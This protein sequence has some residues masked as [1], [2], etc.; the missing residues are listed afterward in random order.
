MNVRLRTRMLAL[1]MS[2]LVAL[3]SP[4]QALAE[5]EAG[6]YLEEVYV[7]VAKTPDE[8]GKILEGKGYK[9]LTGADGKPADLNQ[10]AGSTFKEDRAVV[11]GYKTTGERAKAITDLAVMGMDGAYSFSDYTTL[12]AKY[13]D[14][15]IRPLAERLMAAVRE[16]RENA[17]SDNAGNKA[18]AEVTRELLN[19]VIEDDS[20]GRLGDMLLNQTMQEIGADISSMPED[21]AKQMRTDHPSNLDL[22]CALTQG[23]TEVILLVEQLLSIATDSQPTTWLERL[24]QLGP[25]G[26]AAS[27]GD[28]RPSD[29]AQDMAAKYQDTAKTVANGWEPLRKLLLDYEATQLQDEAT[30]PSNADGNTA[31]S[32]GSDVVDP[33]YEFPHTESA[34][35]AGT[36]EVSEGNAEQVVK[37]V[38]ETMK[39][40]NE[41]AKETDSARA[42]AL[43]AYLK[44]MPYGE[45][46]LYDLFTRPIEDVSANGYEALYPMA[47]VLSPGQVAGLEF[48][49]LM[50]LATT[51]I[52]SSEAYAAMGSDF[53]SVID[54]LGGNDVSL[55]A[56]VNREIFSD[57]VAL[58]S[59]ALRRGQ[60]GFAWS[61]LLSLRNFM[62]LS[63]VGTAISGVAALATARRAIAVRNA[64]AEPAILAQLKTEILS[65]ATKY[66]NTCNKLSQLISGIPE[67]ASSVKMLVEPNGF[68]NMQLLNAESTDS[69]MVTLQTFDDRNKLLYEKTLATFEPESGLSADMTNIYKARDDI[70]ESANNLRQRAQDIDARGTDAVQSLKGTYVTAGIFAILAIASITLTAIDL[71]NYYN[72]KMAPIPKYIVDAEDITATA[73]DGTVTVVRNDSAYYQVART[74]AV[75]DGDNLKAMA[76]YADLNGDV[77]KGWLALYSN[78]STAKMPILA[79]SLKV[80]TGSSSMPNG[81]T[82]AI[83][84]FGSA[85]AANITDARYSY[86]DGA[87]G[88]YAF[89]KREDVAPAAASIFDSGNAA[90]VGVLCLVAGVSLGA[91]GMYL[92]N[93]RRR[94]PVAA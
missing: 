23:N 65:T 41:L 28:Q 77:G 49:S 12:I 60:V 47:S 7:A 19:H 76:D 40:T 87:N 9:V 8:A 93:K 52:A 90:L 68:A 92:Y 25:D 48:V 51:G 2:V 27:Y 53:A 80:V 26:L 88:V 45:G 17:R 35:D 72:V 42:A 16:Y 59:D 30:T 31:Q 78:S 50:S 82:S 84:E 57:K 3:T 71:Y 55:Y 56:S 13:R 33:D 14:S 34:S 66:D 22:E 70:Q 1:I 79:S 67:N 21:Q 91:G 39:A 62:V 10:K 73:A 61:D 89:F 64:V 37:S 94:E 6:D 36:L 29:V 24:S 11:L 63:W 75:R 32:D 86:N 83:H 44:S 85:S 46:T 69:F 5:G 74:N 20:G 54:S 18:R 58:T 43:H 38:S 4:M 81:Y 15:Q